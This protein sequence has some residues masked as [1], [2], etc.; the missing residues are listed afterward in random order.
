MTTKKVMVTAR[1]M[2]EI[3]AD[4]TL[5]ARSGGIKLADGAEFRPIIALQDAE[6]VT[7]SDGN[8][9]DLYG[10]E[11]VDYLDDTGVVEWPK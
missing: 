8:D 11:V 3:P 5:L 6:G 9:L 7:I 2:V 4:A 1:A 10:M